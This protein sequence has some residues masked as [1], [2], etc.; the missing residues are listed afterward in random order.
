MENKQ[1]L[2]AVD[3][4][5]SSSFKLLLSY[6]MKEIS[7]EKIRWMKYARSYYRRHLRITI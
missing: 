7:S 1:E 3:E 4:L 2:V 5:H 6:E